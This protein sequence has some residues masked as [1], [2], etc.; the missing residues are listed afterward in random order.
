MLSFSRWVRSR[1]VAVSSLLQA[2]A[3]TATAATIKPNLRSDKKFLRS[4][5]GIPPEI[6]NNCAATRFPLYAS[7]FSLR[8]TDRLSIGSSEQRTANSGRRAAV[9]FF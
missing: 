7:R 9:Q 5:R 4:G 6:N 1:F 2:V 3:P 8:P